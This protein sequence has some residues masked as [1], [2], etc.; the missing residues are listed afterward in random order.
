[1]DAVAKTLQKVSTKAK[2]RDYGWN[3]VMW[4]YIII[5][6]L[7]ILIITS[8]HYYYLV[9]SLT[10]FKPLIKRTRLPVILTQGAVYDSMY[11]HY[12]III[13]YHHYHHNHHNH[14]N[15]N[16]YHN[17]HN[18]HHYHHH[19]YYHYHNNHHHYY[20]HY[21]HHLIL[22]III[23]RLMQIRMLSLVNEI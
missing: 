11:D 19:Y 16:Y 13:I 6:V 23:I 4:R 9:H 7:I 1:M 3:M 2:L 12:R 5:I 10:V 22:C 15:H 18:Y 14:H 21:H 20:Y 8:R 17:Y